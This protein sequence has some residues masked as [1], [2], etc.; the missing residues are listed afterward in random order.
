MTWWIWQERR[1]VFFRNTVILFFWN[2][3]ICSFLVKQSV[4]SLQASDSLIQAYLG[5][6][7]EEVTLCWKCSQC[8]DIFNL[9][10]RVASWYGFILRGHPPKSL[11]SAR[12]LQTAWGSV[13]WA[14]WAGTERDLQ[15]VTVFGPLIGPAYQ[16]GQQFVS[17]LVLF[18]LEL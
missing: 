5:G 2:S 17:K 9:W 13:E 1:K 3:N 4:F 15:E 6:L 10:E 18:V 16:H 8:I 12:G 11:I 7:E 14:A